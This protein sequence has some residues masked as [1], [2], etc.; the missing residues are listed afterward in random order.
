MSSSPKIWNTLFFLFV[1][2]FSYTFSGWADAKEL[3]LKNNVHAQQRSR[4]IKASYANWTAPGHG[5]MIIPVNTPI[6][7]GNWRGGFYF[8]TK[9]S[10]RKVFFEVNTRNLRISVQEYL[11]FVTSSTKTPLDHLSELDRKGIRQGQALMG[12]TKEGVRIAM[13]FPAPHRT[14]SLDVDQWFYWT[15]RWIS[16]EIRFNADGKVIYIQ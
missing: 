10:G 1:L 15:N 13:G 6:M 16:K 14:L 9:D 8:I 3:Y 11:P 7:L 5:H 2:F 4:H 12:M